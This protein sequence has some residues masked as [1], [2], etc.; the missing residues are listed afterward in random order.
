MG[1]H[2]IASESVAVKLSSNDSIL[3]LHSD[4]QVRYRLNLC[5]IGTKS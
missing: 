4:N 2:P 5:L 1:I 3:A